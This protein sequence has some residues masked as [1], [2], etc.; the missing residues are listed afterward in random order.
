VSKPDSDSWLHRN[1]VTAT[2]S[3]RGSPGTLLNNPYPKTS[4][5]NR[6]FTGFGYEFLDEI[7]LALNEVAKHVATEI[8]VEQVNAARIK[9]EEFGR[10]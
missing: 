5:R 3:P 2:R 10:K 4:M 1:N 9:K 8:L 6:A 7:G